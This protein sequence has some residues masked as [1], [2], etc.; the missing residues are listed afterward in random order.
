MGQMDFATWPVPGEPGAHWRARPFGQ[1]LEDLRVDMRGAAPFATTAVLSA[2]LTTAD[3]P[4]RETE[5]WSWTVN[6]R[7]QGLLAI[8]LA[9]RGDVWTLTGQC[10]A[11]ECSELM[12]L[13]LRLG[14]FLRIEDPLRVGVPIAGEGAVELRTPTG[15]DQ[16][17]WLQA[18]AG[19]DHML[20]RLLTDA[21]TAPL[22]PEA[23]ET[24]DAALAETDPLTA[25]EIETVCPECGA[26]NRIPMDLERQCLHFLTAEQPRL[27][28]DIHRLALAYHW[29]EAEIL[30]IPAA[31]RRQY[32]DRLNEV[33]Q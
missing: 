16:R 4:V 30:A 24:I 1:T 3:E 23:V 29:S 19:P 9:T 14:D 8:T 15:D 6:R 10:Q 32:L 2:C 18:E 21:P 11:P 26:A 31:R 27:L 20:D 22:A 33:W 17:A 5:A 25:L 28:D 7:L 13:P 12:D